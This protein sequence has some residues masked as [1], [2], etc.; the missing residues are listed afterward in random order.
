MS[1]KHVVQ[2]NGTTAMHSNFTGE[3]AVITIDTTKKT[4]VVHDGNTPGGHAMAREDMSN[5][6]TL[7]ASVQTQLKGDTGPAGA[8]GAKGDTGDAGADGGSK[9]IIR[10]EGNSSSVSTT[11]FPTGLYNVEYVRSLG[12]E[13]DYIGIIIMPIGNVIATDICTYTTVS[14]NGSKYVETSILAGGNSVQVKT[15]DLTNGNNSGVMNIVRITQ[16]G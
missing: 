12:E 2:L 4:V 6:S 14:W 5:V 1:A 15:Y 8:D 16:I 7:P 9:R 3:E 11:S 10:F 13:D